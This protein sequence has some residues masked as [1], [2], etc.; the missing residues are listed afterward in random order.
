MEALEEALRPLPEQIAKLVAGIEHLTD[1]TK[2]LRQ[3]SREDMKELRDELHTE[4]HGLRDGWAQD[5]QAVRQDFSGLQG[6]LTQIGFALVGTLLA[7]L[8]ALI[9]AVAT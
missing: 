3:E 9:I 1:E 4:V 2:A 7:A 8:I 5:L 6:R